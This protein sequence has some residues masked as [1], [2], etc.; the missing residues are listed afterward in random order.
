[1]KVAELKDNLANN[2]RSPSAPGNSDRIRRYEAALARLTV[3]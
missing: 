1:V 3:S 2:R